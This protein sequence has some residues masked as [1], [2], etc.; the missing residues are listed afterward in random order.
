[1]APGPAASRIDAD[2][3]P[4]QPG[5]AGWGG[6]LFVLA[7]VSTETSIF[8]LPLLA[9][10]CA[11]GSLRG[12]FDFET[13]PTRVEVCLLL[14]VAVWLL[15]SWLGIDPA[16]SLALSTPLWSTLLLVI[17]IGRERVARHALESIL[18]AIAACSVVWSVD[19]LHALM[20]EVETSPLAAVEQ[21]VGAWLVVPNDF[22]FLVLLW[23]LW[24]K[25][26]KAAPLRWLALVTVAILIGLHL[27][28]IWQLQSRLGLLL[29]LASASL[30]LHAWLGSRAIRFIAIA[31]VLC[32]GFWALAWKPPDSVVVRLE[33]WWSAATIFFDHP[34][35]G[36]G[37]H[38]FV[39]AF[40][41]YVSTQAL[42]LDPRVAPWPHSL[43]L[44]LA[45]ETGLVGCCAFIALVVCAAPRGRVGAKRLALQG[46]GAMLVIVCLVEAST[47]RAWW[48]VLL[49]MALAASNRHWIGTHASTEIT[50]PADGAS[51]VHGLDPRD[52]DLRDR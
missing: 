3:G 41:A 13:L 10:S 7:Q 20:A 11:V 43:P 45:A 36:I 21:G 9:L 39:R 31:V 15:T 19:L 26:A 25:M 8:A 47:L 4:F 48:W 28:T 50:S 14:F 34:W 30:V 52:R 18:L 29:A 44:E 16:R 12:A 5:H 23:P 38:N 46:T 49:G 35:T 32:V 42:A 22:A 6:V 2:L 51:P 1:V 40:P 17:A 27:V 24:V 33:L 37:P